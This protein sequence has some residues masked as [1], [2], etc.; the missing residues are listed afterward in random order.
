MH[1]NHRVVRITRSDDS[2]E[3]DEPLYMI[4]EVFYTTDGKPIAH[5]DPFLG[6]DS[7]KD[8]TETV[9]RFAKALRAPTLNADTD[10]VG[11]F[12]QDGD[13]ELMDEI[14]ITTLQ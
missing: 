13:A 7:L 12:D 5:V 9:E 14:P 1:W 11:K 6:A 3:L 2:T 8:L 4:Q 10:F